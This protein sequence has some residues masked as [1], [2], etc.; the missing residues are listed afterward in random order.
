MSPAKTPQSGYCERVAGAAKTLYKI[1]RQT[2]AVRLYGI[3]RRERLRECCEGADVVNPA[4]VDGK[5]GREGQIVE[6]RAELGVVAPDGP[7]KVIGKLVALLD[8]L[9]VGV[10]LTT[11][12]AE[13]RNVD[14]GVRAG[15]DL[16]VIEVRKSAAC[17]LKAELIHFVSANGPCVL[18]HAGYIAVGLLGSA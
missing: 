18:H 5:G 17:V 13:A 1:S 3:Q 6:I 10:R 14:G 8:S 7:G 12:I 11:E 15:S 16:R 9:D 4:V 2:G